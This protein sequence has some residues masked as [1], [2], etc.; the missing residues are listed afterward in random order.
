MS[1]EVSSSPFLASGWKSIWQRE[2]WNLQP[3]TPGR[4]RQTTSRCRK[5]IS[6]S[7]TT[8]AGTYGISGEHARRMLK[9]A[10]QQGRSE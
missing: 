4:S 10:I 6:A 3:E 7:R 9:K 5:T 2:T 1:M 8:K